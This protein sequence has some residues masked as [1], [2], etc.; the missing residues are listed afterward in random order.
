M[1]HETTYI[2]IKA[3]QSRWAGAAEGTGRGESAAEPGTVYRVR[4]G[5][6]TIVKPSVGE[7]LGLGARR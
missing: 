4:G 2:R 3:I 1:Q 5:E 7:G 6:S